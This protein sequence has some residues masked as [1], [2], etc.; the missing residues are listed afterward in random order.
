MVYSGLIDVMRYF[1][2]AYVYNLCTRFYVRMHA[3]TCP[4]GRELDDVY[5]LMCTNVSLCVYVR[6]RA[7]VR[8]RV[9]IRVSKYI[10]YSSRT[11]DVLYGKQLTFPGFPIYM[12][13]T[14]MYILLHMVVL[15]VQ[16]EAV[17]KRELIANCAW[18]HALYKSRCIIE[19]FLVAA[20]TAWKRAEILYTYIEPVDRNKY[21][22]ICRSVLVHAHILALIHANKLVYMYI[23]KSKYLNMNMF[24]NAQLCI[25]DGKNA[26]FFVHEKCVFKC[27][28]PLNAYYIITNALQVMLT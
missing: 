2:H 23:W 27:F 19:S 14:G 16:G 25:V 21:Q 28:Y 7:R 5:I 3:Y 24:I 13:Y 22:W 8:L 20:E 1:K 6:A 26:F 10:I 9:Y 11:R 4:C 15:C 17:V 18:T 12:M